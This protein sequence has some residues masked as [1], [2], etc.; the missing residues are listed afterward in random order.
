LPAAKTEPPPL[1]SELLPRRH[2]QICRKNRDALLQV[3]LV[4]VFLLLLVVVVV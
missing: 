2:A 4:F 3:F 1:L